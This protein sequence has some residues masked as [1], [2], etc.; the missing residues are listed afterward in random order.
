MNL[1]TKSELFDQ[2]S[3]SE[4][5]FEY[6]EF[7]WDDLEAIRT[8]F[9]PLMKELE[10]DAEQIMGQFTRDCKD[11]HSIRYRIKDPNHLI[12]KIIRLKI[13]NKILSDITINNYRHEIKD[14]LGFRLL[15]V[16]KEDWEKVFDYLEDN[17]YQHEKPYAYYRKGDDSNYIKKIANKGIKVYENE[18]GYRSIHV[19][20]QTDRIK[21]NSPKLICEIQIRTVFEEA[22]SE[23]GHSVRYPNNV[24]NPYLNNYFKIYNR[25]VGTL[26][27][28]GT[29]I[30]NSHY[31]DKIYKEKKENL[32]EITKKILDSKEGID[33]E[34]L[35]VLKKFSL[36]LHE[37]NPYLEQSAQP[38]KD[39]KDYFNQAKRLIRVKP[40]TYRSVIEGPIFLHPKW[41]VRL[42]DS[43]YKK[44]GLKMPNYDVDVAKYVNRHPNPQNIKFI[45]RLSNRYKQKLDQLIPIE[46]RELF[47]SEMVSIL[48]SYF[49]EEG[50]KGPKILCQLTGFIS[51]SEI[52]DSAALESDKS[53][54][55][56]PLSKG[57]LHVEEKFVQLN[58]R[59]FDSIFQW[60]YLNNQDGVVKLIEFYTKL[61]INESS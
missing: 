38:L 52:Y 61:W 5:D 48:K 37:Q 30:R 51:V 13:S 43:K 28:M 6:C 58:K 59:K 24:N 41:V 32:Q 20:I 34:E 54:E 40:D 46:K 18:D 47:K 44:L 10:L 17:Y 21:K 15:H 7:K 45:I 2:F 56:E 60:N 19:I 49:G 35:S 9:I 50:S 27:E 22:W 33:S 26:D 1:L 14:I 8:D 57:W 39:R 4:R 3:I 11:I 23:I 55:N 31:N 36:L 53:S 16:F 42:R 29:F 25:F 12:A